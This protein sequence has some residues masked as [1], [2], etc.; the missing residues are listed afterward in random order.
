M[1]FL[2]NE[3]KAFGII[4]D[5]TKEPPKKK[6]PP[7]PLGIGNSRFDWAGMAP[8]VKGMVVEEAAE[9]IGCSVS[10]ARE[11]NRRGWINLRNRHEETR[12]NWQDY[13]ELSK[14][15]ST[16]ELAKVTGLNLRSI[17]RANRDGLLR[18]KIGQRNGWT[19][20]K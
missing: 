9:M 7:P 12:I 1:K 18:C 15:Y 8:K 3:L 5:N 19:K 11:A 16:Y 14:K 10:A 4:K 17:Q 13:F 20:D 6:T 2:K